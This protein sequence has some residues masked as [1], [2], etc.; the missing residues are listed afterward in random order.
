MSVRA[1][2]IDA[3]KRAWFT[4]PNRRKDGCLSASVHYL[5]KVESNQLRCALRMR[6]FLDKNKNMK[7]LNTESQLV[8]L[9]AMTVISLGTVLLWLPG[10]SSRSLAQNA[11][12]QSVGQVTIT[13]LSQAG[14]TT[15]GGQAV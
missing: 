3:W 9:S 15:L 13:K 11:T 10:T 5:M 2:S 7:K 8:A 12:K 1:R 4:S 14:T 6:H